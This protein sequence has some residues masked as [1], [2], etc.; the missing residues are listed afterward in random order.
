MARSL[1]RP[2]TGG[3]TSTQQTIIQNFASGLTMQQVRGM[4]AE[5][6]EALVNTMVGA[7]GGA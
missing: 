5:N 6:N 3:N 7:L 1:A 2:I 4:I